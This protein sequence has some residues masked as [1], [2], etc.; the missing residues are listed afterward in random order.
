[1]PKVKPKLKPK[2]KR[3]PLRQKKNKNKNRKC[4]KNTVFDP[5]TKQC[6]KLSMKGE[7]Y[8]RYIVPFMFGEQM[9]LY[10]FS[11]P[12][13]HAF[14]HFLERN[15]LYKEHKHTT[16]KQKQKVRT[17]QQNKT[18]FQYPKTR[19]TMITRIETPYGMITP[20]CYA[21]PP[22]PPIQAVEQSPVSSLS[23]FSTR[24]TLQYILRPAENI[25]QETANALYDRY[26]MSNTEIHDIINN[27]REQAF[28]SG[29]FDRDVFIQE[30]D[31][32]VSNFTIDPD[33]VSI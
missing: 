29:R 15:N 26:S 27:A 13:I 21:S 24:D 16:Q 8:K 31:E 6:L 9:F 17:K 33:E 5:F 11:K 32:N 3:Q 2:P 20:T 10:S 4:P 19:H 25:F 22:L 14:L 30:I 28:L 18:P 1:M 23:N 7:L 12:D